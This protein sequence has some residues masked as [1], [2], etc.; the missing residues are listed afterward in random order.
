MREGC[1]PWPDA[2]ASDYRAKGYW[3]D[4]VLGELPLSAPGA[5]D[6]P[7]VITPTRT[8]TYGE[9]DRAA[10]RLA[11]GLIGHGVESG[12]RVVVQLPN[13]VEM[14]VLFLAL[15]RLGALPVFAL[16]AHRTS[17][18]THLVNASE[19][20]AY[21]CPDQLLDCDYRTIAK[22]VLAGTES[23]RHVL[24]AGDPGPFTAL[25]ELDADPVE[26]P[27]PDPGDVALFLLSGGTSGAPKLIPRTHAD[28]TY[29]LRQ[30]ARLCGLGPDKRYLCALPMG[31]NFALASPGVL[32]TLRV[33]G[34]VVLAPAPTPESCFPLIESAGVTVTSLVPPLVPLWLDAAE[35][36]EYDLSS[37]ELLQ[38]GGARLAPETASEVPEGLGC[39]L[40]QVYG[41]AEGLLNYTRLDDPPSVVLHTQGRPLSPGDEIRVIREDGQDARPGEEGE[42]FTRGPYTVRGYYRAEE[43]NRTAFTAEGYYRTGDVVRRTAAGYFEVVGRIN[44]VVNRGGEK[45]PAQ[46]VEEH[47]LTD[48]RIGAAAVVALP[49]PHMGEQTCACVVPQDA[50]QPPTLREVQAGLRDRGIA[51]Y[52][53]PDRLVVLPA[54]PL[55]AVG[56]IDKK[57]LKAQ[58]QG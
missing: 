50:E 18:I 4:D 13:D 20:V 58:L 7:A 41:M 9:L 26:L 14:V 24:V 29:Q 19:A 2:F 39:T 23:L 49:H 22:E 40:Q 36:T 46:E 10:D 57:A 35:W 51:P 28:Y 56:K 44:D 11:A 38:V 34:T 31:H 3:T 32:G 16:P 52:K 6:R 37:L 47:L 25:A 17:E 8:L 45:V 43:R 30:S 55:T 48:P 1:T 42:L 27:A 21:V 33:G 5:R 53:L 54:M 12:D 15:F